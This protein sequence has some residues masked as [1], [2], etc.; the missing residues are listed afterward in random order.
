MGKIGD[1]SPGL[2]INGPLVFA[3]LLEVGSLRSPVLSLCP[4]SCL[5]ILVHLLVLLEPPAR[6]HGLY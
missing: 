2:Q 3:E 5:S 1:G 4:G 6:T